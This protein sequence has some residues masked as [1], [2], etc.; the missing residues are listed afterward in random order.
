MHS[1]PVACLC[2]LVIHVQGQASHEQLF[3]SAVSGTRDT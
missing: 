2:G 3:I 1:D